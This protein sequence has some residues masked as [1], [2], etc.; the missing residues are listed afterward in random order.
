M[1]LSL[2][3]CQ[4]AWRYA[5]LGVLLAACLN[6]CVVYERRP[7]PAYYGVTVGV[8]PPPP[9]V[10]EVPQPRLG[11]VWTSG[12]WSWDGRAYVWV[13]GRWVAERP[14]YHWVPAHWVET[15]GGWRFIRGHWEA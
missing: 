14:G 8:A 9:R 5:L 3:K 12:Y 13:E 11:Y 10:T 7:G 6:G 15:S 1:R 2:G 4:I